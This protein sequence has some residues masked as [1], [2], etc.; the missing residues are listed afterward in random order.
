MP[1]ALKTAKNEAERD[2]TLGE[3]VKA[4]ARTP[5]EQAQNREAELSFDDERDLASSW[6]EREQDR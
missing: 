5:A 2:E 4:F 3:Y 6:H 1:D